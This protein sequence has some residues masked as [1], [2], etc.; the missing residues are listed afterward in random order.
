MPA[1]LWCGARKCV[2]EL[3]EEEKALA[4]LFCGW[5]KVTFTGCKMKKCYTERFSNRLQ[6]AAQMLSWL[7]L[8]REASGP[9][10]TVGRARRPRREMI[11]G[12]ITKIARGCLKRGDIDWCWFNMSVWEMLSKTVKVIRVKIQSG[13]L[14]IVW[15]QRKAA[16]CETKEVLGNGN[17]LNSECIS[18]R[19]FAEP[20]FRR[21]Q[22]INQHAA[23]LSVNWENPWSH[24]RPQ[25]IP[26]R[27]KRRN[28]LRQH[29]LKAHLRFIIVRHVLVFMRTIKCTWNPDKLKNI[30]P[31]YLH[32]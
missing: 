20:D 32:L 9:R 1:T 10:C 22:R 6:T 28:E 11:N 13:E 23:V 29:F 3:L 16:V 26:G 21:W 4:E 25:R 15:R 2:A 24:W 18:R 7:S 5:Q 14:W 12:K 8:R 27:R 30:H 17:K 19:Q 31:L